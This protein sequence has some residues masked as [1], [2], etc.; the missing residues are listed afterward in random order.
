MTKKTRN[1]LCPDA[2]LRGLGVLVLM[3]AL[4]GPSGVHAQSDETPP[5]VSVEATPQPMAPMVDEGMVVPAEDVAQA[6]EATPIMAESEPVE[7]S[8]FQWQN[9]VQTA[10]DYLRNGGPAIWAIALLSVVTTGLVLWKIWRLILLGAW[11]QSV[12]RKAVL[13]WETGDRKG[14]MDAVARGRGLRSRVTRA[15]MAAQQGRPEAVAREETTRVAKMELSKAGTGLRALE[16]IAAIAPL[17]GL[18][19]TV[20]GM[21]AAFQ[22]LQESGNKAD[23]ALLAGGIWEALLTT[24]A[25]MA[26]AI[27]ASIALTWFEAVIDR[28][29]IDVEDLATRIF[30]SAEGKAPETDQIAA[31]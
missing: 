5:Q 8:P 31:E 19:G 26:V 11:H 2:A 20:L 16:L 28:M 22:A 15:A 4:M 1:R 29:R 6:D 18:L 21:I 23:P 30:V 3:G 12:A 10:L 27:P 13:I 7:V 17:L 14:A 25:G 24:A 9:G